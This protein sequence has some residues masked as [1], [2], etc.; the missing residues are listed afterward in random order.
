[1][2]V[3]LVWELWGENNKK[4]K[5]LLLEQQSQDLQVEKVAEQG[6]LNIEINANIKVKL[7]TSHKANFNQIT[8]IIEVAAKKSTK[9]GSSKWTNSTKI[10]S[11]NNRGNQINQRQVKQL[12][13]R[14]RL[15]M[16]S[17]KLTDTKNR[18]QDSIEDIIQNLMNQYYYC[19]NTFGYI[20]RIKIN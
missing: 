2:M 11:H 15:C 9:K 14:I 12:Q 6:L 4:S 3:K 17:R 7:W 5:Q 16:Y 20:Y 13:I 8:Q 1:M 19:S 18:A 10:R